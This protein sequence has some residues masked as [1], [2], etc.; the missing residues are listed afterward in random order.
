MVSV[1]CK[2]GTHNS[3]VLVNYHQRTT[4]INTAI[5]HFTINPVLIVESFLSLRLDIFLVLFY[6]MTFVSSS[7]SV[8][9]HVCFSFLNNELVNYEIAR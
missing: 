3:F 7:L 1:E 4:L 9:K 5:K 6:K 2:Y 8:L